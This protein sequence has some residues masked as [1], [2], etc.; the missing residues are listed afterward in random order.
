MPIPY[1]DK[2]RNREREVRLELQF[3]KQQLS[4]DVPH[5][6]GH[7]VQGAN[8]PEFVQMDAVSCDHV[9]DP[10]RVGIPRNTT[11]PHRKNDYLHVKPISGMSSNPNPVGVGVDG[12]DHSDVG[13]GG[14]IST[15]DGNGA[16]DFLRAGSKQQCVCVCL[17]YMCD[18]CVACSGVLWRV[19]VVCSM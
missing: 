16:V 8:G 6:L 2:V 4:S 11:P 15:T 5:V 18:V 9:G 10:L 3:Q 12:G 7:V 1:K 17:L 19:Y 14:G 13:G